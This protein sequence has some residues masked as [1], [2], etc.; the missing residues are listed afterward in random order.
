MDFCPVDLGLTYDDALAKYGQVLVDHKID[1][2]REGIVIFCDID[3][4][5]ENQF[6]QIMNGHIRAPNKF[7]VFSINQPGLMVV[8]AKYAGYGSISWYYNIEGVHHRLYIINYQGQAIELP[9]WGN[10]LG[11]PIKYR[12]L[13]AVVKHYHI[14]VSDI[15]DTIQ[16]E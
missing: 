7:Q 8:Y 16:D 10:S 15:L 14:D 4:Y 5:D 6:G 13:L 11:I 2:D 3:D 12:Y 1:C 9:F